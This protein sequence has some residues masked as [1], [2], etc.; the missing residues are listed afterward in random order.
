MGGYFAFGENLSLFAIMFLSDQ[1]LDQGSGFHS[2]LPPCIQ[3]SPHT[4]SYEKA[5]TGQPRFIEEQPRGR[6]A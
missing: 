5:L 3:P 4:L 2:P 6:I 1:L